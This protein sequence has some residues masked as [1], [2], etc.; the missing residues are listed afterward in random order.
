MHIS[1]MT[2]RKF[3]EVPMA[4]G[5]PGNFKR[6]VILPST[7]CFRDMEFVVINDKGEPICRIPG[8]DFIKITNINV[9]SGQFAIDDTSFKIEYLPMSGLISVSGGSMRLQELSHNTFGV[10]M[11]NENEVAVHINDKKYYPSARCG[12]ELTFAKSSGWRLWDTWMKDEPM[13]LG[14]EYD[15]MPFKITIGDIVICDSIGE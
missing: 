9:G 12:L 2:I 10:S 13:L 7:G 8:K 14:G 1:G 11:V 15:G 5:K 6:F 3:R 4:M